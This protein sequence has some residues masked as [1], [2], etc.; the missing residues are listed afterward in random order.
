MP[1]AA[2]APSPTLPL[3]C[4]QRLACQRPASHTLH[5]QLAAFRCHRLAPRTSTVPPVVDG[6]TAGRT[7]YVAQ[8]C[9]LPTSTAAVLPAAAPPLPIPA[10]NVPGVIARRATLH[11]PSST[12]R[13]QRVGQPHRAATLRTRPLLPLL[14]A[15]RCT[16]SERGHGGDNRL[17]SIHHHWHIPD[18]IS[19][20]RGGSGRCRNRGNCPRRPNRRR[21][22]YK[23]RRSRAINSPPVAA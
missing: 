9:R 18:C 1:D 20:C 3:L 4:F 11:L 12:Q 6:L 23:H 8:R 22:K 2:G 16:P 15:R 13:E 5:S 10:H 14:Q 21:H 17:L 7:R 19:R